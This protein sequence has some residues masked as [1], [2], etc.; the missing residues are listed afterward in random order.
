MWGLALAVVFA[1][2]GGLGTGSAVLPV[3]GRQVPDGEYAIAYR[4]L[5]D[6][7]LSQAVF[8][9][10]LECVD[11][12]C[13]LTTLTIGQ[14]IAGAW[15]P[16]VQRWSTGAGDLSVIA[17]APQT[18]SV[19]FKAGEATFRLRLEF[20]QGGPWFR[21][22]TSFSGG[23]VKDSAV[24]DRVITWEFVPLHSSDAEL[25]PSCPV[26]VDALPTPARRTKR[27]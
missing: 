6:G 22:V 18:L 10:W 5:Q 15:Y 11:G 3:Q 7:K 1:A 9:N 27:R 26:S 2:A 16:K 23:V 20:E 13:T 12:A 4:Q 25:T 24:L 21:K 14:C 19:Q 17:S 8:Q